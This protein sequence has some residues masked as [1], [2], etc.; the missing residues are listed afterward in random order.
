MTRG[1]REKE[2]VIQRLLKRIKRLFVLF[3]S[4]F[5]VATSSL[6]LLVMYLNS[7][8]LPSAEVNQTTFIYS[9]DGQVLE[10]LYSGENRVY[11][12][13]SEVPQSLIEATIAIEDRKF[14]NHL[15]IDP[16]RIGGAIIQDIKY[17]AKVQGA[18]T[19]TQQL[20]KNLYLTLDK[21]WDRK[22]K[23]A[24]LAIQLELQYSKN[25]ILEMY[26]NEIYF[27][28]SAYGVQVAAQTFFNKDV[29]DLNLAESSMLAGIPNGPAYFSP[30]I[31]FTNAK[32]R[33]KKVL[34]AMVAE[35]YLTQA[36]AD[37]A[38]ATELA[39]RSTEEKIIVDKAP[40]FT[41]YIISQLQ[42]ELNLP[43]ELIYSG[44]LKVYTTLDTKMQAEAEKTIAAYLPTDRPLQAALVSIDPKTGYLKTMVGGR[45]YSTSQ[46][47]R[48]FATRQPG[49][50]FKPFLY[51]AALEEGFTPLTTFVSEPTVFAF[52]NGQSYQPTNY[53]DR[54]PNKEI[55]LRYAL[56]HS[57]NIYAVKTHMEIGMD[58]L[59]EMSKNL[60]IKSELLPYPSL[61]LGSQEVSPLEMASAYSTIA[62]QGK[63]LEPT[64]ILKVEDQEGNILYEKQE[65][66][67]SQVVSP[68]TAFILT[69]LMEGVFEPG[70]T[71]FYIADRLKRPIAGKTGTTD[72]DS[73]LVGFT[74]HL[75]TALWNGFDL[76]TP[77]SS[78]DTIVTKEIW[79][80]YMEAVHQD[81]PPQLFIIPDGVVNLY[82]DADSGKL[83]TEE[84]TNIRL[85]FF[86]EGSE[87]TEYCDLHQN[88][89]PLEAGLEVPPPTSIW[90]KFKFWWSN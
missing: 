82:I 88:E 87:P 90:S 51:L 31:D 50:S 13:L 75:V 25:Q 74:P 53:G 15:G 20:A 68:A 54:Y 1:G 36:E 64:A 46:F 47:N 7:Q 19:I 2:T 17:L 38:Y 32:K 70:G 6:I 89:T 62:N 18:S 80:E 9:A 22:I 21:T 45:D 81:I 44:G 42:N 49:S 48:V 72:Y 35:N 78:A 43:T 79:A 28:H 39:L 4:L 10:S 3:L 73:W 40:Y 77:L 76:N 55:D 86:A 65:Y 12:P 16:I 11:I 34:E 33:Q 27:G 57:D 83:A 69:Y 56:A 5:F 26:L 67:E 71:G 52:G 59:V 23:E 14:F 29:A 61:A 41:D 58:K 37:Q 85:E 60:G 66:T 24:F 30:F 8:P 84:C 63:Y